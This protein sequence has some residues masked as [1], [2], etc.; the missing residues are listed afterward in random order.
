[1]ASEKC[2]PY[3][4]ILAAG[5]YGDT[6]NVIS[7]HNTVSE[8]LSHAGKGYEVIHRQSGFRVGDVVHRAITPRQHI[9]NARFV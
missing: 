2:L 7:V 6:T 5:R 8:A 9:R 3:A 4:V 1:M